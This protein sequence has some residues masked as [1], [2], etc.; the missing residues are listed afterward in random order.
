MGIQQ[1]ETHIFA[2]TP[3]H[4]AVT[5]LYRMDMALWGPESIATRCQEV[6]RDRGIE[7]VNW[8]GSPGIATNR[9]RGILGSRGKLGGVHRWGWWGVDRQKGI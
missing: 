1:G 9:R 2:E 5:S 3:H 8:N 6:V 7:L 4:W